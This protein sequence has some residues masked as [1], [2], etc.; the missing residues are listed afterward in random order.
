M[1]LMIVID[2]VPQFNTFWP[3]I[4]IVEKLCTVSTAGDIECS[5]PDVGS[6]L[7]LQLLAY[8]A[9]HTRIFQVLRQDFGCGVRLQPTD[10]GCQDSPSGDRLQFVPDICCATRTL[11]TNRNRRV[12]FYIFNVFP[13]FQ[14]V[15]GYT[16]SG[17]EIQRGTIRLY[18]YRQ[19]R[20][21]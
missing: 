13:F 12:D 10:V 8:D 3:A 6:R 2:P 17:I 15:A 14:V 11:N 4:I 18:L 9:L 21:R 5:R 19:I 20:R 1:S 7:H 16:R